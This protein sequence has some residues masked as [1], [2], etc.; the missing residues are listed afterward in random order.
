[1]VPRIDSE[2]QPH[3]ESMV[4]KLSASESMMYMCDK[5]NLVLLEASRHFQEILDH[6]PILIFF[7][8]FTNTKYA[9][10]F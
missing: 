3:T 9:L 4:N 1:M 8:T 5:R 6:L 7:K 2:K 10:F